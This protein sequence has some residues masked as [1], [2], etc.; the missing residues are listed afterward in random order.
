MRLSRLNIIFAFLLFSCNG[1]DQTIFNGTCLVGQGARV[2]ETRSL[3][4]FHSINNLLYAD[5]I[6]SQAPQ[7]AIRITAQQ[8]ILKELKTEVNNGELK[9]TTNKC[10]DIAE[11][12]TINISIPEIKSIALAGVGDVIFQNEVEATDLDIILTGVGDFDL[13]GICTNLDILLTGVGNVK[14]FEL[15]ADNCDVSLT[16]VGDVETFVNDELNVT[17]T[18]SGNVLYKGNPTVNS[19]ITGVGSVV[20]AN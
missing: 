2:S 6:L 14:A 10:V 1:D 20:D 17:I 15:I 12:I 4:A 18:G 13:Q 5:I 8:N 3:A 19:S 11:A 16:G 9:L 7:E